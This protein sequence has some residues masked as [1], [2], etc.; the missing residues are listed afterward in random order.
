MFALDWRLTPSLSMSEIFS[1][2]LNLSSDAQEAGFVSEVAPG[3]SLYGA[4]PWS[5]ANLNYRLQGLYNAG[6]SDAVDINHQLQMNSLYQ[7]VRNTLFIETS[8]SIS[9]QN[10]SN[11][12]I[13]A[14][15]ISGTGNRVETKTFNI[16][17]YW[18][19]HFGQYASGLFKVGYNRA[20]FDSASNSNQDATQ[21]AISDSESYLKQASIYSGSYFNRGSWGIDYSG[22]DN[23]RAAGNDVNFES[24]SGNGR[25][26]LNRNFNLFGQ[27]GYENNEFQTVTSSSKNGFFYTFGGQ[28]RP[29]QLYSIEVGLGNNKHVTVELNPSPNLFSTVTYRNKDIGLNRGDSWDAKLNYTLGQGVLSFNYFQE[30]TTVQQMLVDRLAQKNGQFVTNPNTGKPYTAADL[31]LLANQLQ[32]T[33]A[34]LARMG[35]SVIDLSSLVDDVIVRKRAD[36]TFGYQTGKSSFNASAYNEQRTYE[37]SALED[38][39]Y[40]LSGGWQWQF[41]PRLNFFL[42]PLWQST[43]GVVGNTRYD[44]AMGLSRPVPI[45]LGRPLMA[46]TKLELRHIEQISDNS[47]LDYTENRAT[48]NFAVQ[49]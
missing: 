19:P 3:I 4:S 49:F 33:Q 26:Y 17:P 37:L 22:T 27:A 47:Q 44:I 24:Y 36:L 41:S 34:D 15:N 29:S 13:A 40:G 23:K 7:A 39:V 12:F 28:W 31:Q 43:S 9:Q 20:S 30:T 8:S 10:A 46:N 6:G 18:T 5:T 2:N 38:T 16:S 1:D 21:F 35:Y 11:S 48:A 25:Y 32:L 45:N 42:Q 14:D